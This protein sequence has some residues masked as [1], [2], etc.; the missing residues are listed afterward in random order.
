MIVQKVHKNN[1]KIRIITQCHPSSLCLP[2]QRVAPWRNRRQSE[3]QLEGLLH[4]LLPTP[5]YSAAMDPAAIG[6]RRMALQQA[7]Q[8][9][10]NLRLCKD[11]LNGGT[12]IAY[13][14]LFMSM[15]AAMG[16][17]GIGMP[18]TLQTLFVHVVMH[19]QAGP[20]YK[21]WPQPC[22]LQQY[23]LS[24]GPCITLVYS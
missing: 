8:P 2:R 7:L 14:S 17:R 18:M 11:R 6:H 21:Y 20:D 3:Q 13:E 4:S 5:F 12:F 1:C 15:V 24:P 23:T 10:A 22:L 9:G 19:A 16:I